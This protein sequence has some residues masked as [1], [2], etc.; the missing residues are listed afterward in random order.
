MRLYKFTSYY[1]LRGEATSSLTSR[2]CTQK[3]SQH[4]CHM[5]WLRN[6]MPLVRKQFIYR[7]LCLVPGMIHKDTASP[8]KAVCHP[9]HLHTAASGINIS[10]PVF[11]SK[12]DSINKLG[13][14]A[15]SFYFLY[16]ISLCLAKQTNLGQQVFSVNGCCYNKSCLSERQ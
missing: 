3:K 14:I 6:N 9:I 8:W 1:P 2:H 16:T 13:A 15:F 7:E 11:L 5:V 4:D 10:Q 12:I